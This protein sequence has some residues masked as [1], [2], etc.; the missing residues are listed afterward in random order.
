MINR[1]RRVGKLVWMI[2]ME[3]WRKYSYYKVLKVRII[4]VNM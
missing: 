4:V 2:Y 3:V 1:R